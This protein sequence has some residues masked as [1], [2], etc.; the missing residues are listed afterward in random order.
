MNFGYFGAHLSPENAH[1]HT[2]TIATMSEYAPNGDTTLYF[3]HK[4]WFSADWKC[5]IYSFT[6]RTGTC[7]T[8]DQDSWRFSCVLCCCNV[9]WLCFGARVRITMCMGLVK[10]PFVSIPRVRHLIK[11]LRI[12]GVWHA[13]GQMQR[14]NARIF[15]GFHFGSFVFDCL[16]AFFITSFSPQSFDSFVCFGFFFCFSTFVVFFSFGCISPNPHTHAQK[17]HIEWVLRQNIAKFFAL[18]FALPAQR[19]SR[20]TGTVCMN[21]TRT[22]SSNSPTMPTELDNCAPAKQLLPTKMR[23]FIHSVSVHSAPPKLHIFSFRSFRP[24]VLV[25]RSFDLARAKRT[26]KQKTQ[27]QQQRKSR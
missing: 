9:G 21:A 6:P 3:D 8:V 12:T 11:M 19:K 20:R 15:V 17:T 1:T 27:Q 22:T 7:C 26:G 24:I 5:L 23:P 4:R 10:M 16:L 14:R 18:S 25:R 2:H 13:I